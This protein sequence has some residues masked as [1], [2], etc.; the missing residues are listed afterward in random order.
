M[1]YPI[2]DM[3]RN[4]A[5][6]GVSARMILLAVTRV[7]PTTRLKLSAVKQLRRETLASRRARA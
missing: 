3:A 6:K 2:R 1:R 7:H 4:M 5:R